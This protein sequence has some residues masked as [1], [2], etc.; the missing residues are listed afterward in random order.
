MR[1][2]SFLAA[3][4]VAALAAPEPASAQLL[5]QGGV[6]DRTLGGVAGTV[7]ATV[8][9]L[10]ADALAQQQAA[11]SGLRR[12]RIDLLYRENPEEIF[13]DDHDEPAIRGE[14]L[15]VSPSKAAL[16]AALADGFEIARRKELEGLGVNLVVLKAPEGM[17]TKRALRRL[18]KLDPEGTYDLNHVYIGSG[19]TPSEKR[20]GPSA[21]NPRSNGASMRIGLIDGGVE[22]SHAVFAGARIE[23]RAFTG[24]KPVA[25]G[26]G[27]AAASLIVGESP[28]FRG[29]A[30]GA[31][32]YAADVF[33]GEPTGGAADAIAAA[34]AWL[35][36]ENVAVINAS[37]V[38]PDN[39]ALHAV[40]KAVL[41]KGVVIVAA[42][43][44]DGPSAL[45]LYPASY[46]GVIGVTAV[47]Q[48]S[49]A[50]VEAGRGVQVDFAAP[51]ADMA[52]A[53][54]ENGYYEVRGTSFSAPIVAGL[55]A[56]AI[57]GSSDIARAHAELA[58]T[59]DDLGKKGR[60]KVYGDG[61]VG[62]EL[63]VSPKFFAKAQ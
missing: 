4:A 10:L 33:G 55:I 56:T 28:I 52:A 11:L 1:F 13:L 30:P 34:F 37:L 17:S 16:S 25:T 42:G 23:E 43:G 40:V 8:D 54:L 49:K 9:P 6:V 26:H 53:G 36:A 58:A 18:R 62:A 2:R 63:R 22:T 27:T 50:I 61:L 59:A 51:G 3:A 5:G 38:G 12:Q 48:K 46:D 21:S 15:A 41:S 31:M 47:D 7:G 57:D 24:S 39:A 45:P 20:N 44:N 35:V 29:S 60:D 14:A 19:A 32:L